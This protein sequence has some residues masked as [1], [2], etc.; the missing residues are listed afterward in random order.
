MVYEKILLP[1]K[2]RAALL[3][4]GPFFP[5]WKAG[6]PSTLTFLAKCPCSPNFNPI[7]LLPAGTLDIL[8]FP[9][10]FFFLSSFIKGRHEPS[11]IHSV[12]T[13]HLP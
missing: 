5:G 6:P 4:L 1:G 8:V 13:Q 3:S 11:F 7:A 10:T 9:A 2:D 12:R